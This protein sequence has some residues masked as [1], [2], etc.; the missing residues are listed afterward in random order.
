[1][2]ILPI[3]QEFVFYW[4]R[5][6]KT[7]RQIYMRKT[8]GQKNKQTNGQIYKQTSQIEMID[9]STEIQKDKQRELRLVREKS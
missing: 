4:G 9:M 1:M 2:E 8:G 6:P 7:D 5:C 3:L